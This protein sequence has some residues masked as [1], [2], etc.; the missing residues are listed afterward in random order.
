MGILG[1][2]RDIGGL[3]VMGIWRDSGGHWGVIG[4]HGV[5]G[6]IGGQWGS[7]GHGITSGRGGGGSWA[8]VFHRG[9]EWGGDVGG[10]QGGS[11]G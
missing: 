1:T 8:H 4:D 7:R 11:H 2:L 10:H 3:G 5:I 6:I 9:H